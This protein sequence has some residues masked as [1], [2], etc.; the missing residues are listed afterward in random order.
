MIRI[1]WMSLSLDHR[2]RA[3]QSSK[4]NDYDETKA[5]AMHA[6]S[7]R[8]QEWHEVNGAIKKAHLNVCQT[9]ARTLEQ[10]P[11]AMADVVP[12]CC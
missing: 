10:N 6:E 4:S 8:R 3:K 9:I 2:K 5:A 7:K 11:G 1:R 12:C